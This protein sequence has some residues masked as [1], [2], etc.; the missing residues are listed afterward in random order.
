MLNAP[1]E[2]KKKRENRIQREDAL[3]GERKHVTWDYYEQGY[4]LTF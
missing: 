1:P 2:K 3:L 4:R